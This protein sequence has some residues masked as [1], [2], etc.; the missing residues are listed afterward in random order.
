MCGLACT[1]LKPDPHT[2]ACQVAN[3]KRVLGLH[4]PSNK[5]VPER[6]VIAVA[7]WAAHACKKQ[8]W[9]LVQA[10]MPGGAGRLDYWLDL[11]CGSI[12]NAQAGC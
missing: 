2:W 12:G 11:Q 9:I 5:M 3:Q 6:H 7:V 8:Q 4:L 1:F 10:A